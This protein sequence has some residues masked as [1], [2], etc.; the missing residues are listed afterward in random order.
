MTILPNTSRFSVR[1]VP[2]GEISQRKHTVD[3]RFDLFPSCE[4]NGIPEVLTVLHRRAEYLSVVLVRRTD[5]NIGVWPRGG[6][7]DDHPS[8][9][10]EAIDTSLPRILTDV[11]RDQVDPMP[12]S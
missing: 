4:S 6:A 2:F 7:I 11:I 5:I 9:H 1:A 10:R 3:N 8:A 12:V